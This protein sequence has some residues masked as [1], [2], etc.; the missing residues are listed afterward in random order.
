MNRAR[1]ITVCFFAVILLVLA[2]SAT[3]ARAQGHDGHAPHWSY[4][5]PDGPDHWGDLDP[6]WNACKD[7]KRQS[8]INIEGAKKSDLPAIQFDY[9]PSPLKIINNGHTIQINYDAGSSISV[10]GKQYSLVQFHFHRPSEEK[11][12]GHQYD[13][14]IHLVHKDSAGNL[15]VIGLLVKSGKENPVI[16]TLWKN[17]PKEV[18]KETPVAGVTVNATD[19]LPAD[20]NY[21]SF[22]GSLTTP[23]CSEGVAWMVFEAPVEFSAAQID[24]FG[25]IYPM[26]A[27][28]TQPTN[29]R[30]IDES[31]LKK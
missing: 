4:S 29:G 28:P 24:T 10:G 11:I 9:K 21:Y 7:G 1:E 18:G 31:S 3:P 12:H 5:G 30:G 2:V 25:K 23:P 19:L 15:A 14:V 16:E 8:P 6:A 22:A 17:L 27:R 13:M 26:N 20:H